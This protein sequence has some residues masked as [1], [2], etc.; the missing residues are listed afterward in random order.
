MVGY[1][2]VNAVTLR[3]ER[4]KLTITCARLVQVLST[5]TSQLGMPPGKIFCQNVS[6]SDIAT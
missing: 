3:K 2:S 4:A 6:I 5:T 1:N